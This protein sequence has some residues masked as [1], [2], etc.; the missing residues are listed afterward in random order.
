MCNYSINAVEL[1]K[2]IR[3]LRLKQ[4]KMQS[5]FAD[6][7]YISPS[8]LALIEAGKRIPNLD[9]L[10]H[11]ATMCDVSLDYL[12]L[13]EDAKM[14]SLQKTF[15]RLRVSYSDEDIQKGLQLMEFY[16]TLSKQSND[17]SLVSK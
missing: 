15:D 8:Y 17:T 2:R 16:L 9:V 14:D 6:M 3:A 5:Y 1:G 13:G 10:V 4:N 11:L 7:L 12:I